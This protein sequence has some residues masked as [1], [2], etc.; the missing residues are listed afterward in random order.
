MSNK[1]TIEVPIELIEDLSTA[2]EML[3][4][5]LKKKPINE[6]EATRM[7]Y[8]I[9]LLESCNDLFPKNNDNDE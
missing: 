8:V 1:T 7:K 6:E 2:A 5:I 4:E 3:F 9:K